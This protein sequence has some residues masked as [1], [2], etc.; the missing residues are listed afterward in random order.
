MPGSPFVFDAVRLGNV[1]QAFA[2][3]RDHEVRCRK[4]TEG[5]IST[6]RLYGGLA[7]VNCQCVLSVHGHSDSGALTSSKAPAVRVNDFE[8]SVSGSLVSN[9]RAPRGRDW[10]C[11]AG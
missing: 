6:P 11:L 3:H 10:T 2:D 7:V 4:N 5:P 9:L 1:E 8:T